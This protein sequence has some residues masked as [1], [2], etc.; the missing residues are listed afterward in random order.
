MTET[1][2]AHID[3]YRKQIEQHRQAIAAL[4]GA[5]QALERVQNETEEAKDGDTTIRD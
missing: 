4:T 1:I 5:I 3:E 2:T